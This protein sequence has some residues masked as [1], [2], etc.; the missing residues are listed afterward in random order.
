MP[1]TEAISILFAT[2]A[3]ASLIVALL[4]ALIVVLGK[5]KGEAK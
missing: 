2:L 5:L 3:G 1:G 4:L